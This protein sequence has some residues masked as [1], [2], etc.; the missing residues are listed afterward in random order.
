MSGDVSTI[1]R[2]LSQ[3]YSDHLV[4]TGDNGEIRTNTFLTAAVNVITSS[5]L[6]SQSKRVS[7][8]GISTEKMQ[9]KTLSAK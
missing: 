1:R 8:P 7:L 5:L 2:L 6:R 4:I 3:D 9:K